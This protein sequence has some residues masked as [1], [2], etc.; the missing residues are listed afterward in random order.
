MIIVNKIDSEE[1]DLAALL[2]N[3]RDEF[4]AECLPLNLPAAEGV[5]VV[6]CFFQPEGA[7]T[8]FSNVKT[9]HTQIV[10][11]VVEVDEELM[12]LYL[13][14]GEDLEPEQ[15]HAPFEKALREGHL[16]PICFVSSRTGAGIRQLLDIFERLMPNPAEGNPPVFL[17]GEGDEPIQGASWNFAYSPGNDKTGQPVI[18]R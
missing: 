14:Q 13:E 11:Q 6:D 7:D 2:E 16:I 17:K 12:E 4:G 1:I 5:G 3:I 8:A 18:R 15:L 9:A 10:D